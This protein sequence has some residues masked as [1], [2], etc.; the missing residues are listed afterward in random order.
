MNNEQVA[1]VLDNFAKGLRANT[2]KARN[3]EY[4][5]EIEDNRLYQ[6]LTLTIITELPEEK[7]KG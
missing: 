6:D 3:V 5:S 2:L 7:A 4:K 1:Q